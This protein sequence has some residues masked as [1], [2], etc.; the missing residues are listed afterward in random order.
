MANGKT[1]LA[2]GQ[3]VRYEHRSQMDPVAARKE[4]AKKVQ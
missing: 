4:K 3:Q 1:G 2:R